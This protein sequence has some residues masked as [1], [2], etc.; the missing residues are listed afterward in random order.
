MRIFVLTLLAVISVFIARPARA[1]TACGSVSPEVQIINPSITG[2]PQP[3]GL[4]LYDLNTKGLFVQFAGQGNIATYFVG[5]PNQAI[6]GHA[7]VPWSSIAFYPQALVQT[8]SNCP[9]LAAAGTPIL[10]TG[11]AY[12]TTS[13]FVLAPCPLISTGQK[14]T[15]AGIQFPPFTV[16]LAVYDA[17]TQFLTVEFVS[18]ISA[19]FVGVPASII[20]Q[21][22][23]WNSLYP[24][25]E[26]IM[27]Q[28]SACPVL[29]GGSDIYQGWQ[30]GVSAFG[31]G[32]F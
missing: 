18:G 32:G 17:M 30:F 21:P 8:N 19:L 14:L 20:S 7:T 3:V 22:I 15:V 31:A 25:M 24:Y 5:V 28:D 10:T 16:T 13:P 4:A 23:Q 29:A 6:V 9:V 27:T 2:A 11:N 12:P 26:A 1:D